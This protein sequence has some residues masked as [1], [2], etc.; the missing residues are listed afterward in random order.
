M[1]E[2]RTIIADDHPVVRAG[3]GVILRSFPRIAVVGEAA[4]G[5]AALTLLRRLH[6]DLLV[7]DI[8]LP[9]RNGIEVA[10]VVRQES[11]S[12]RVLVCSVDA[13]EDTVLDAI[14][15]GVHGYLLKDA[16]PEELERAARTVTLG[17]TYLSP[18]IASVVT[19]SMNSRTRRRARL[20][21]RERH[22]V[23]LISEGVSLDAISK[24]L[25][26]SVQTVKTHRANA[27]RK[28]DLGT[29]AGLV[30]WAILHGLSPM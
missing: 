20:S 22:V 16:A 7:L 24:R 13:S 23:Q 25:F 3:L 21:P 4:D 10:R 29:T 15:A 28:L 11:P 17:R 9:E 6:P 18:E 2:I 12:V 5:E 14:N 30:R 1:K 26:V 27:M 19:D 8:G